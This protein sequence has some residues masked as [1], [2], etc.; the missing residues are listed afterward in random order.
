MFGQILRFTYAV[1]ATAARLGLLRLLRGRLG[2]LLGLRLLGLGLLL[3][4]LGFRLL[5]L[6]LGLLLL[7]RLGLLLLARRLR[8]GLLLL[9]SRLLGLLLGLLSARRRGAADLELDNILT[10][11][12]GVLLVDKELLDSTGLGCVQ[13]NVDLVGLDGSN[14]LIL[15][16]VVADLCMLSVCASVSSVAVSSRFDHCFSVP[17]VMDS[18]ISGTLTVVTSAAATL[19]VR[20]SCVSP[21]PTIASCLIEGPKALGRELS[22]SSSIGLATPLHQSMALRTLKPGS[23]DRKR[24]LL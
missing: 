22:R 24:S 20:S 10:N 12:N 6:G 18:A 3:G 8:R 17:S 4:R 14:L 13:R 11:G 7:L 1:L 2:L 5:L 21:K 16:N 9:G 23:G 15:L 19:A